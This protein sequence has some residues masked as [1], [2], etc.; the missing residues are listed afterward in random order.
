MSFNLSAYGLIFS[1]HVL[2]NELENSNKTLLP[3]ACI[4]DLDLEAGITY[5]EVS[6]DINDKKSVCAVHEYTESPGIIFMPA[7]IMNAIGIDAGDNVKVVQKKDIPSG[8][9]IKIR[10]FQKAF[11]Q[12]SNP[13]VVL[14][15]HISQ[16]YPILTQGEVINIQYN[17]IDYQ[18]EIV[19]TKPATSIQTTNC[20]INLDFDRPVD[21][22]EVCKHET[23][24]EMK[25]ENK[26]ISRR[27][28]PHEYQHKRSKE[29]MRRFPGK[30]YRLGSS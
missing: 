1:E 23:K 16:Y 26:V 30:G 4:P 25:D 21:M 27:T 17:D 12:I 10:P 28:P 11:I 18:I 9:Y 19:E 6:S 29:D 24:Q 8:E 22:E 3:A 14:E 7:R 13:K 2:M 15:K 20:D 5:L